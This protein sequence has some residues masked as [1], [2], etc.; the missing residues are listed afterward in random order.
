MFYEKGLFQ[1]LSATMFALFEPDKYL[2]NQ[3]TFIKLGKLLVVL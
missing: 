1:Q 3:Q 2:C